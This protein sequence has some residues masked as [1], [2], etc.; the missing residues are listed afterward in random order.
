MSQY[1]RKDLLAFPLAAL[2]AFVLASWRS[3]RVSKKIIEGVNE[4]VMRKQYNVE[5]FE[6]LAEWIWTRL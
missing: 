4:E 2:L 5:Y 3:S 6:E 1:Q